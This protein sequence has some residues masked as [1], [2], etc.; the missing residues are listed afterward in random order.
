MPSLK[1]D[2]VESSLE[3]KGFTLDAGDHRYF[4]LM[5]Q[6]KY[7]GIFTKTSRGTKYKTLGDD[8]VKKMA[9]QIKL[10]TK[11][12]VEFVDCKMSGEDYIR[13]LDAADE[14]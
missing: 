12:F 4:K 7:T 1:R 6:G 14:L 10:T 11:Q 13:V 3:R 2:Q 9:H 5:Y 8:L